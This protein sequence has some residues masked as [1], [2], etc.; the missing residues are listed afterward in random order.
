MEPPH[1]KRF[2]LLH[3]IRFYLP[4]VRVSLVNFAIT[5]AIPIFAGKRKWLYYAA[6]VFSSF[7]LLAEASVV[8]V[9]TVVAPPEE[10][11]TN[12]EGDERLP[13][14]D[15]G[16]EQGGPR[17]KTAPSG[18]FYQ[19]VLAVHGQ[20]GGIFGPLLFSSIFAVSLRTFPQLV[21]VVSTCLT[22]VCFAMTFFHRRPFGV[23]G[24]GPPRADGE[25][26]SRR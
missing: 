20:L 17:R 2:T 9:S 22:V 14:Q 23:A 15:H 16:A 7:T 3:A 6:Q 19:S 4:I 13:E 10:G 1:E 25:G 12:V 24:G 5:R 21:F 8:F 11:S 18:A 26:G